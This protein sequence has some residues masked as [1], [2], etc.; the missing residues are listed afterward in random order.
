MRPA[1]A[2]YPPSRPRHP[3]DFD[4]VPAPQPVR[5][6]FARSLPCQSLLL[7]LFIVAPQRATNFALFTGSAWGVSLCLFSEED[8]AA[9]RVTAE[10]PLD[11]RV[12]K[13]GDTWHVSLPDVNP[14]LLYGA[15]AGP[16][17]GQEG[18]GGSRMHARGMHGRGMEA[19]PCRAPTA[20]VHSVLLQA[21]CTRSCVPHSSCVGV[22][23]AACAGPF[24]G[25]RVSGPNQEVDKEGFD[26]QRFKEVRWA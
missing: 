9:G 21:Q 10:I 12:N 13:T 26:G 1:R 4:R 19:V 20:A 7:P 24:P 15:P 17:R 16:E 25:Y 22:T 5:A 2:L 8:L 3:P 11:P 6:A 14:A 18:S 23:R